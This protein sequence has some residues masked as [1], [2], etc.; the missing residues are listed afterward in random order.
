MPKPV[1]IFLIPVLF[2]ICS[3]KTEN[4][5]SSSSEPI[6]RIES[7][8]HSGKIWK[9]DMDADEKYL[10]SV[11]EDRTARVWNLKSK[12][13][14]RQEKVLRPPIYNDSGTLLHS[15]AISP[16][17]NTVAV[18]NGDE[19]VFIYDRQSGSVIDTLNKEDL[20]PAGTRSKYVKELAFSPDGQYLTVGL[21]DKNG[22]S[23]F[24]RGSD[25]LFNRIAMDWEYTRLVHSTAFYFSP[26]GSEKQSIS[27]LS[28]TG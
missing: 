5:R 24:K 11:S 3:Q 19:T 21:G 25:G 22:L 10:V 15:V 14:I 28:E 1:R 2:F 13:R 18:G 26:S 8:M 20:S 17:G 12:G 7:G 27:D 23:I 4:D 9:I 6:I 16:D